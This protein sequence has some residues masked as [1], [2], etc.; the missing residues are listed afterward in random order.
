MS[1]KATIIPCLSYDDAPAAIEWLC[2]AFGFQKHAVY[3]GPDNTI[4][5][6]ELTLGDGMIMLGTTK[7]DNAYG[8]A[9]KP[10][11]YCGGLGTMSP[12]IVVEDCD[13]HYA[14]AMAAGTEIVIDIKTEDYGGR[15][16]T[17]KDPEGYVWNFGSYDP[18]A[19]KDA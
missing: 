5:H 7:D 3:P 2:S 11:R 4:A 1:T 8:R 17:C 10:P 18:W 13:A 14:V 15:G 12:Y 16:Y 9:I 19:T 6:A